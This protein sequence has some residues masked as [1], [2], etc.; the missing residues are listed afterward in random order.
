MVRNKTTKEPKLSV[1][2]AWQA[3][4]LT[5]PTEQ[6]KRT[7]IKE[8]LSLFW[9]QTLG[10]ALRTEFPSPPARCHPALGAADD[11]AGLPVGMMKVRKLLP[12]VYI[13]A[14]A[15]HTGLDGFH[16]AKH[17]QEL[18]GMLRAGVCS[19]PHELDDKSSSWHS[20]NHPCKPFFL[21][22]PLKIPVAICWLM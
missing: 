19:K 10:Q 7:E 6:G 18:T 14:R 4:P 22:K 13:T 9:V 1:T 16:P 5:A 15:V 8:I 20:K 21:Q 12:S 3:Q 17:S 2:G 11:L